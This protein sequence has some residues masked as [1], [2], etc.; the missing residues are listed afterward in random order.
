MLG[1]GKAE[2]ALEGSPGGRV[3]E[4]PISVQQASLQK[5]FFKKR[6][7]CYVF[8]DLPFLLPTVPHMHFIVLVLFLEFSEGISQGHILT[9]VLSWGACP[10]WAV[11]GTSEYTAGAQQRLHSADMA[12]THCG[13]R[14]R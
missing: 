3:F 2:D 6:P 14:A 4:H 8:P 7:P 9:S 5:V 12:V 10:E 11:K 1:I 13:Y